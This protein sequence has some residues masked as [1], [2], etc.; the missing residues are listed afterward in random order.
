MKNLLPALTTNKCAWA[1]TGISAALAG[2]FLLAAIW[3]EPAEPFHGDKTL[4]Q[5]LEVRNS[6]NIRDLTDESQTAIRTMGT[7]ALPYLVGMVSARDSSLRLKLRAWA[8]KNPS[9]RKWIRT[10]NGERLRGAAGLEALG[11]IAA[12]AIPELIP[13]LGDEQTAYPAALALG[14]IGESAVPALVQCLTNANAQL[15]VSAVQ[16]INFMH[17]AEGA[18]PS[19]VTCLT[20]PEPTVRFCAAIAL[21]DM[22]KQ[23]ETVVPLLTML[24]DDTDSSVR[25]AGAIALGLYGSEAQAAT[26]KLNLLQNDP[27]GEVRQAAKTAINKI[28]PPNAEAATTD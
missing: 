22:R 12:P 26:A 6:G 16:A 14:A 11:P 13:L 17:G 18:I 23:P 7:N 4:R 2:I 10:S 15:R 9:I 25:Q 19:L 20:D 21:G 1:V 28:L 27:S 5:W 8:G 24:L 3:P